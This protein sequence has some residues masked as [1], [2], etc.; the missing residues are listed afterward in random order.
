MPGSTQLRILMDK[1]SLATVREEELDAV[2]GGRT[3]PFNQLQFRNYFVVQTNTA[4]QIGVGIGGSVGQI[5][6]QSNVVF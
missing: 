4:V 1:A 2:S 6:N 5:I 3:L